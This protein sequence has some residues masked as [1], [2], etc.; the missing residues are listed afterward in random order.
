MSYVVNV[1]ETIVQ[2]AV[3]EAMKRGYKVGQNGVYVLWTVNPTTNL[4]EGENQIHCS[5][6]ASPYKVRVGYGNDR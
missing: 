3:Q 6:I 5:E 1:L 2:N 4:R